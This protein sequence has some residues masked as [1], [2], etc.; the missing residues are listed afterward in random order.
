MSAKTK[1]KPTVRDTQYLRV[2]FLFC[3]LVIFLD[4]IVWYLGR[5]E[6]LAFLDIFLSYVMTGLIH[7]SGLHA[8]RDSNTI[9]LTN[10]TWLVT[11]ECT[12]IFIMLIY[13]SFI[14]VYPASWKDRG[15][16]L[17]VGIPSIF[18]ANIL[19]LYVMAWIDYLNP[20]YSEFFHNY[21][22]QVVFI[23]MVVFMWLIWIDRFVNR[24]NK[25]SVPS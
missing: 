9:Y 25:V 12:A 20:Q 7:A 16:A 13:S 4:V 18:G 6:H 1:R 17:L 2:G 15:I 24:E 14:M 3:S 5:K 23:V 10:S 21:M 8:I 19:R 22:W 11:T